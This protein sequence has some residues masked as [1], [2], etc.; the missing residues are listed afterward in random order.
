MN[1][2]TSW[3]CLDEQSPVEPSFC[4]V[5]SIPIRSNKDL[6]DFIRGPS[7]RKLPSARTA[8]WS[9]LAWPMQGTREKTSRWE[10]GHEF[11]LVFLNLVLLDF[12][13]LAFLTCLGICFT[14]CRV[15]IS[16]SKWSKSKLGFSCYGFVWKSTSGGVALREPTTLR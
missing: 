11:T 8:L 7:Q 2:F 14:V 12:L 3:S 9:L 13:L 5:K 16:K 6:R 4:E 15:L 10:M 1:S